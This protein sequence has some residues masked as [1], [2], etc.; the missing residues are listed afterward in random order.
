MLL[1][2]KNLYVEMEGKEILSGINLSVKSGELHVIMGPNGS[3]KTTL[4]KA[5]M[6]LSGAKVTKGDILIDGKS[7]LKMGIDERAKA[8]IFLQYQNPVEI[9][10][11]S[12]INFLHAASSSLGNSMYTKKFMTEIKENLSSLAISEEIIKR[13]LNTGFSGGEK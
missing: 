6:G 3:G 4:A 11:V 12:F 13:P 2:I 7:I 9:E 8:G 5:I 1:E 10:G